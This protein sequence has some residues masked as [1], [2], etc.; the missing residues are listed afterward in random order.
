MLRGDQLTALDAWMGRCTWFELDDLLG[1][2]RGWTDQ[3]EMRVPD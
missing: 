2:Q 1:S 3:I